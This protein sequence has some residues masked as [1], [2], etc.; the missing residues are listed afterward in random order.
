M[1]TVGTSALNSPYK[2]TLGPKYILLGYME[3]LGIAGVERPVV[4]YPHGL[5]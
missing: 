1:E 4:S 3:G 5:C 2:G